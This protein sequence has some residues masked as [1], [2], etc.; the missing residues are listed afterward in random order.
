[1]RRL[2]RI[3]LF[4]VLSTGALSP[5]S[6]PAAAQAPAKARA[7][8]RTAPAPALDVV[9][10]RRRLLGAD[11]AQAADAARALGQ[12]GAPTS[13]HDALLDGL[14]AGLAPAAA[15]AAVTA[16]AAAPAPADVAMLRAYAGHRD[17]A[18]RVAALTT[19][20]GY[21]AADARRLLVD[22]LGDRQAPVRH[23]AAMALARS[24]VKDGLDRMLALLD[25]S[26]AAGI[27]GLAAMADVALAQTLSQR[28]S[29]TPAP[30]LARCLGAILR[31][32]DFGPDEARLELVRALGQIQAAEALAELTEY[33]A[34]TPAKPA[35]S[36]RREAESIVTAR[37]G[38]GS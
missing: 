27:D 13:A 21:P 33:V 6:P 20:G 22:A 7:K 32:S 23:A 31:R 36:S 4:A 26:D 11:D 1:M 14:A 12:A 2:S 17:A 34:R 3:A 35:L 28:T 9:A 29:T 25:K 10:Q 16:L 37:R 15:A 18:V 5:W 30:A 19:L 24:R 8:G 38:G